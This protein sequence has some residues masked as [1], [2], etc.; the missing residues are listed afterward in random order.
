MNDAILTETG[1]KLY[2]DI[3][4]GEKKGGVYFKKHGERL[5]LHF[6]A[7]KLKLNKESIGLVGSEAEVIYC[8][9]DLE[10]AKHKFPVSLYSNDVISLLG[11]EGTIPFKTKE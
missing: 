3:L 2:M 4:A 9:D 7:I 6:N 5:F 10:L 8:F 1:K 11:T